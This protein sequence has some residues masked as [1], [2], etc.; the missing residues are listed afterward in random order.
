LNQVPYGFE[1]L[2]MFINVWTKFGIKLS[3]GDSKLGFWGEKW[4]F[5]E[6]YLSWLA[7]ASKLVAKASDADV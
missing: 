2:F 4:S 3:L 7:V 6:S 5:P 1:S